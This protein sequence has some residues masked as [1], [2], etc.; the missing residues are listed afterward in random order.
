MNAQAKLILEWK[1][2]VTELL[3]KPLVD[4]DETSVETT[5]DEYE[6]STKLQDALNAYLDAL[7]YIVA[8]RSTIIDIK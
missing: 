8:D 6:D 7:R 3:L 1:Q 2:K 5:G 4:K